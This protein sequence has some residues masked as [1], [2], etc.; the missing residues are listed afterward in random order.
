MLFHTVNSLRKLF[1]CKQIVKSV[2]NQQ[3]MLGTMGTNL[4]KQ[5]Q[6]AE[7]HNVLTTG[8]ANVKLYCTA[9][10]L[11]TASSPRGGLTGDSYRSN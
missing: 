10:A 6:I 3:L 5:K 4:Y 1:D 9:S 7:Y 2:W 11:A 8:V